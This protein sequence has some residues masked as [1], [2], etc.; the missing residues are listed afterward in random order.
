[1]KNTSVMVA[2][3]GCAVLCGVGRA[4]EQAAQQQPT[5]QQ[6]AQ[7][8]PTAAQTGQQEAASLTGEQLEEVVV[9]TGYTK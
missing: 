8:Q 2:T 7:E 9:T 3:L 6:P 4:Q 5:Q 1:M